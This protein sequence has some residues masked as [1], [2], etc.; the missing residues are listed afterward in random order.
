MQLLG[1]VGA[2][3]HVH[4]YSVI[5]STAQGMQLLGDSMCPVNLLDVLMSRRLAQ[6]AELVLASSLVGVD[7]SQAAR[8]YHSRN[9]KE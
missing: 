1:V 7:G 2:H 6:T 5:G 3:G 8:M 4:A 9:G